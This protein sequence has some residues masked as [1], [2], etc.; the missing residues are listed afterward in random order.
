MESYGE[1]MRLVPGTGIEPVRLAAAD[2]KSA[3]STNFVTQ[4]RVKWRLYR[5][6]NRFSWLQWPQDT[7]ERGILPHPFS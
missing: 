3:T 6:K 4:A 1:N 7:T 5:K 2:F